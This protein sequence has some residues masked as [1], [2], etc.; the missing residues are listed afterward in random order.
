MFDALH[1]TV[2]I[3]NDDLSK[4]EGKPILILFLDRLCLV[5]F[6]ILY[7]LLQVYTNMASNTVI[8]VYIKYL[9]PGKHC[10]LLIAEYRSA[11]QV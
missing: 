3:L 11:F 8:R 5:F 1:H 10:P 4:A 7:S 2:M 6:T 9:V